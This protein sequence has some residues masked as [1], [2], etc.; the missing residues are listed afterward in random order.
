VDATLSC[1]T[2]GIR[3]D[4]RHAGYSWEYVLHQ[5]VGDWF[6]DYDGRDYVYRVTE[7]EGSR[8]RVLVLS[9]R[10]P[11]HS[12][13]QRSYGSSWDIQSKAYALTLAQ[14]QPLDYEIRLNATRIVT[15][16]ARRKRR[17]DVWDAVF[18]EDREDPRSPD[19]VYA[20]YLSRKLAGVAEVLS[21]CLTERRQLQ[22]RRPGQRPM[23][24]I[25]ANVIGALRVANGPLLQELITSG[26]GRAKGFGCG[27]LCLSRPGTV[28]LHRHH[29]DSL[30]APAS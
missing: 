6:G 27:L 9:R 22:P 19:V 30:G 2:V 17:R 20:Q 18:A 8:F 15:D 29:L 28:L 4:P 1:G 14:G 7:S 13:V 23:T 24:I 5:L 25:A 10:A 16:A 21:A 26:I 3:R 11:L 12:R